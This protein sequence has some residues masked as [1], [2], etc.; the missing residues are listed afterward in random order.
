MQLGKVYIRDVE[1]RND[2]TPIAVVAILWSMY[3]QGGESPQ[4]EC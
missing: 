3:I 4:P 1:V 2:E